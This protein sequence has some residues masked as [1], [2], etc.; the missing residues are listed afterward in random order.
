VVVD[1]RLELVEAAVQLNGR[2]V[3]LAVG[4]LCSGDVV[5]AAADRNL[6]AFFNEVRVRLP[7]CVGVDSAALELKLE[8]ELITLG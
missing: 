3:L 8:L 2:G 1:G 5:H 4:L 7:L 6:E